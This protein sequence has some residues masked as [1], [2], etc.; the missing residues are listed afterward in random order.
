MPQ[1]PRELL[2]ETLKTQLSRP[3]WSVPDYDLVISYWL[4]D[5]EDMQK[6]SADPEW[7]K[8][9]ADALNWA[10]MSIGHLVYGHEIVHFTS[11]EVPGQTPEE[12]R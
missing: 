8:L 10:N 3:D 11:D 9:E 7:L 12:V 6:L 2:R 1:E 4:R 5:L